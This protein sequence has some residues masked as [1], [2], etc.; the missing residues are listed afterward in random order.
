MSSRTEFR[1][2]HIALLHELTR[3]LLIGDAVVHHKRLGL[4]PST[5]AAGPTAQATS[6]TRIPADVVAVGFEHGD[7]LPGPAIET[8]QVFLNKTAGR[9]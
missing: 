5:F 7:P 8:F 9:R 2:G 1:Y 4:G 6:L 3:A